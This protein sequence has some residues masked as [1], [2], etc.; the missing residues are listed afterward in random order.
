MA[1]K[2]DINA[3]EILANFKEMKEEVKK[4]LEASLERMVFDMHVTIVQSASKLPSEIAQKYLEALGEPE[5]VAEHVWVISLDEKGLWIEEAM[6]PKL[7]MKP[8]LLKGAKS[9]VIPFKYAGKNAQSTPLAQGLV[10]EIKEKLGKDFLTK[11][12]KNKGKVITGPNGTSK[13]MSVHDLSGEGRHMSWV[14]S[15]PDETHPLKR[16]TVYQSKDKSGRSRRDVLVFRTVTD[17][18]KSAGKWLHPG[19]NKQ[20]MDKAMEK[21]EK[22]W[23]ERTLPEILAK[24]G[25]K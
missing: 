22:E 11:V 8:G 1:L 24:W 21:A 9:R 20:F 18:P 10:A 4:D 23:E 14:K 15:K 19:L 2:F 17:G 5:N 12:E 13:K 3:E 25:S 6:D 7:D 16:L